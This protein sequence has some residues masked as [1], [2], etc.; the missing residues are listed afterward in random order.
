MNAL[1]KQVEQNR[2]V[3]WWDKIKSM[4]EE[5]FSHWLCTSIIPEEQFEPM[6]LVG[7]GRFYYEEDISDFL[8]KP[9][10]ERKDKK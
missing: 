1:E 2:N 6:I 8:K 5:E 9:F 10:A 7:M 4:T 3:T